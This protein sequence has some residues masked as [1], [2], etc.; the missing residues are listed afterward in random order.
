M[1]MARAL[2]LSIA[3]GR[4]IRVQ[5]ERAFDNINNKP[6]A[7]DKVPSEAPPHAPCRR[8]RKPP[9]HASE[10]Q[11]LKDLRLDRLGF[12]GRRLR[13]SPFPLLI[14]SNCTYNG[15]RGHSEYDYQSK[16][17]ETEDCGR[18]DFVSQGYCFCGE[19]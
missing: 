7:K 14:I 1:G 18:P 17:V 6:D 4:G 8:Y 19:P 12:W 9:L 15:E 3:C 5:A 11:A 13:S 16:G 10:A 2:K